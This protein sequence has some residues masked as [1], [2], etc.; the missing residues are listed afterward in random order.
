[1]AVLRNHLGIGERPG[2]GENMLHLEG[3]MA[4]RIL[5]A[6]DEVGC[7]LNSATLLG[8]AD[9]EVEVC[10]EGA[11][12]LQMAKSCAPDLAL[13]C[14]PHVERVFPRPPDESG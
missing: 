10:N 2:R 8:E 7:L 1:M 13:L 4:S 5:L 9:H 3:N 14:A 12:F 11:R 6:A